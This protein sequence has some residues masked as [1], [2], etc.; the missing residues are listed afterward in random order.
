[1]ES[2]NPLP[3]S[4]KVVLVTGASRRN[5][6]AT[7]IKFAQQGADVV[8]HAH[9]SKDELDSVA[10]EIR[11]LGRKSF[12][13]LGDIANESEVNGIFAAINS[14]FGGLDILINNAGV[15]QEKPFT[16]ITLDE[17]RKTMSIIVDGTFLCSRE[18]IRS[19]LTRG[20]GR[21]VNLGGLSAHIGARQRAHVATAK[22][23][24]LGM[25]RALAAEYG[26]SG[27]TVNCIVPGRIGGE[28]SAT[29]GKLPDLPGDGGPLVGRMGEFEDVAH[30]TV[31]ICHPSAGYV[32]GQAIHVSGGLYM[33]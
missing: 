1:M 5:G 22:A 26:R 21:I 9:Q 32:T 6:R 7:A 4:G 15:R 25:T 13:I 10:E 11:V 8:V 19:M 24:L 3:F 29:A 23:A 33:N 30:M 31:S 14:E 2:S 17:W 27:I 16:E 20:G 28:R 18:A 12:A